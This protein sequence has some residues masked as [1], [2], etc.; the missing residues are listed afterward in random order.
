MD[1]MAAYFSPLYREY[2][3][4]DSRAQNAIIP[5]QIVHTTGKKK[6]ARLPQNF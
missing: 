1:I 4:T 5:M 3:D 2:V 6:K